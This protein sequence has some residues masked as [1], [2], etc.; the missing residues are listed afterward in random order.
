MQM[1][2]ILCWFKSVIKNVININLSH[3]LIATGCPPKVMEVA[4]NAL[5]IP[6]PAY[7]RIVRMTGNSWAAKRDFTYYRLNKKDPSAIMV[8]RAFYGRFVAY[9]D[10]VGEKYQ[11]TTDLLSERCVEAQVWR[12]P[13][14]TLRDYQEPLLKAMVE[15]TEGILN[16]STG[17]G[18]TVLSCALARALGQKMTILV[19]L[20]TIQ[21]QFIREFKKWFDYDVGIINGEQKEIKDITVAMWQTLSS[22]PELTE[23][24]AAQTSVL[25]V[26]ECHGIVSKERTKILEKFKPSRLYGLSATPKRSKEDGRTKAISFYMGP[27]IAQHEL[28]QVMPTV[29]VIRTDVKIPVSHMYNEMVD[30]LIANESRNKL[31]VGIA[32]A[33]AMS[34]KKVLILVKRVEHCKIIKEMLP[35]WGE[36]IYHADGEDPKRNETLLAM[37]EQE[38]E[39]MIIIGTTAMLSVGL[40]IPCLDRL[41]MA[42]D[43]KSDVL[44][45]QS[46]GRILRLFEGK[47]DAMIYDLF[48]NQNE[49]F[50]RQAYERF[51]VYKAKGWKI[52]G[53]EFK[54]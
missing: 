29:D 44:T 13:K 19:P 43:V 24:L 17:G 23:K 35:D 4:K 14:V 26:D 8:P 53:L 11:T 40:D 3:K 39:F 50:K 6:N 45:I 7:A 16:L 30:N 38:R 47:Q 12:W 42:A 28:P 25:V 20:T 34:G 36:F 9:L 46:C 33:E 54:K 31:I 49:I 48:D 21:N 5:T 37:R 27:I 10:R 41:I 1:C 52:N 32:S 22:S 15:K 51:K 18:K 2:R